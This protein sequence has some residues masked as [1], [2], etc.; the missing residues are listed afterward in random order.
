L[1][2]TS[3]EEIARKTAMQTSQLPVAQRVSAL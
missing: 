1:E 2:I 3:R